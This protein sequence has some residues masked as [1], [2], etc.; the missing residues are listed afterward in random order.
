M[1]SKIL[2]SAQRVLDFPNQSPHVHITSKPKAVTEPGT[3]SI[4][5]SSLKQSTNDKIKSSTDD[6]NGNYNNNLYGND[7]NPPEASL[8][9]PEDLWD[10]AYNEIK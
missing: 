6:G 1:G 5:H 3:G 8:T 10:Q 9:L 2:L 7:D 4:E